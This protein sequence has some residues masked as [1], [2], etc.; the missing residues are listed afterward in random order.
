VLRVSLRGAGG[1]PVHEV[2]GPVPGLQL[3]HDLLD[4]LRLRRVAVPE[5]GGEPLGRGGRGQGVHVVRAD[6]HLLAVEVDAVDG[7]ALAEEELQREGAGDAVRAAQEEHRRVR[8]DPRPGAR[9]PRSLRGEQ[10]GRDPL[11]VL[12]QGADQGAAVQAAEGE[13]LEGLEVIHRPGLS[14][15]RRPPEAARR[16]RRRRR[17]GTAARTPGSRRDR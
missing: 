5:A 9:D 13:L 16:G 3:G 14:C 1:D 6:L 11:A 10:L 7:G 4:G 12:G 2:D 8:R 17:R 15:D